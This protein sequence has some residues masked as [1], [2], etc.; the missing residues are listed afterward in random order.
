MEH[1]DLKVN[2]V[3]TVVLVYRVCLDQTLSLERKEG[4]DWM[5]LLVWMDYLALKVIIRT[6]IKQDC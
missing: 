2:V 6:K 3:K 5:A 4:Q 1:L